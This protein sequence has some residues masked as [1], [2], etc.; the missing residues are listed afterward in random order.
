MV[1]IIGNRATGKTS[2]LMLLAKEKNAVYACENPYAMREKALAYGII[3]ITF[4]SYSDL[5]TGEYE[6]ASVVID[7]LE[8]LVKN[9]IGGTLIG[10]SLTQGD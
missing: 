2:Q 5:F 9:Y 8:V 3:G 6:D 4:I 10:Y 7:E 1:R